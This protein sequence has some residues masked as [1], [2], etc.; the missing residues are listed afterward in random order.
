MSI[1]GFPTADKI[2]NDLPQNTPT[3]EHASVQPTGANRYALEVQPR[4][5]FLVV[6]DA[7]ET[8]STQLVIKA[9]AHQARKH[10]FIRFTQANSNRYLE[11]AVLAVETDLIY[12]AGKLP[13]L[14]SNGDTFDIMRYVTQ[15][16]G[17]D[18]QITVSA[19]PGPTQFV[20]DGTDTEVEEST[21]TPANSRPLPVK[22]LDGNGA[23]AIG[24]VNETAPASDTAS[25]GL[26]GR[27]QRIA[28]RIT[29]LI[30]LLPTS[31]GQ[32]TSANSFAVTVASD[33]SALPTKSPVNS[34]GADVNGTLTGTTASTENAPA[35][36]VGFMLMA[37]IDNS[38]DI[39][40][41]IGGVASTTQ[42][43]ALQ[44]GR[45]TGFIPCSAN[46]SIC[47]TVG[48]TNAYELIWILSA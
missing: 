14:P 44:P 11:I 13:L 43:M 10:D 25:S 17:S 47:A 45:D 2:Q 28:Q 46:I 34:G 32:K 31:L 3:T 36:A 22:A 30:A 9:T 42:G 16:V 6:S 4:L 8:G 38:N 19:N 21:S 7:C 41:R 5:A 39:R 35:N 33:Q 12:L 20:Y 1:K 27:L 40:F 18:G 37:K 48:G 23:N 24:N 29:S 15:R 26:N